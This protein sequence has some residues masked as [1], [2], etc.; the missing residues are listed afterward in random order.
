MALLLLSFANSPRPYGVGDVSGSVVFFVGF[1]VVFEVEDSVEVS[2][3]E[4]LFGAFS[5][6]ASLVLV[7]LLV[8]SALLFLSPLVDVSVLVDDGLLVVFSDAGLLVVAGADA[9]VEGFVVEVGG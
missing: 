4:S 9:L 1:L 6:F 8:E 7:V 2:V 5:V 3:A